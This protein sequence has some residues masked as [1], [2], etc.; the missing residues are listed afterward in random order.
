[1]GV[2]EV[3]ER[4]RRRRGRQ[5]AKKRPHT[6]HPPTYSLP[7]VPLTCRRSA[8]FRPAAATATRTWPGGTGPAG[9]GT[10][11]T[12]MSP[13]FAGSGESGSPSAE[14]TRARMVLLD[15]PA[16]GRG[17]WFVCGV[18]GRARARPLE[19]KKKKWRVFGAAR[20]PG[21]NHLASFFSLA[22]G[23]SR[24]PCN[25]SF[26]SPPQ[27]SAMQKTRPVSFAERK[28]RKRTRNTPF[29]LFHSL[30]TLHSSPATAA[31]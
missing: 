30:S 21:R 26:R 17:V 11:R 16:I 6:H 10:C 13:A 22:A 27:I 3:D 5:R 25:A 15:G 29:S 19:D 9:R 4:E 8:K 31:T 2:A 7:L 14:T 1:M 23:A 20:K 24:P 12:R 18:R 28:N